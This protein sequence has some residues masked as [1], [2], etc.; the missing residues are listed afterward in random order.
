MEGLNG[1]DYRAIVT[2]TNKA[3]ETVADVGETCERVDPD[4]LVWL[5]EQQLIEPVSVITETVWTD[6]GRADEPVVPTIAPA[7]GEN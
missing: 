7:E 3:N 2:L 4:S 6:L 1:K 5:L